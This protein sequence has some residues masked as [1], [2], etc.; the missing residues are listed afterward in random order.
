MAFKINPGGCAVKTVSDGKLS[1]A[2]LWRNVAVRWP[3]G[4]CSRRPLD[5]SL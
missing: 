2:R 1:G 5:F 3:P 4:A